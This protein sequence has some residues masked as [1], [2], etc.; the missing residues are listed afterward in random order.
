MLCEDKLPSN[1]FQT[2]GSLEPMQNRAI[3]ASRHIDHDMLCKMRNYSKEKA[4]IMA[5][6]HYATAGRFLRIFDLY[7][8]QSVALSA[9]AYCWKEIKYAFKERA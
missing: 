9:V 2:L 4:K 1:G 3:A 5:T 8:V 7:Q 6:Q